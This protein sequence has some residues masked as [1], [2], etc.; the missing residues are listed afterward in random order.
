M[1]RSSARVVRLAAAILAMFVLIE[2]TALAQY[3]VTYLDANQAGKAIQPPDPNLVNAW[4]IARAPNSPYWVSDNGTGK[5]TL[6]TADGTPQGLVVE[7]PAAS[8]QGPGTPSGIVFNGNNV[9]NVSK[10]GMSGPA[11]FIF[12]TQDG[13]ISGWN[14]GVDL[15]HAVIAVDKSASGTVYTGLAIA[16]DINW[17]YAA[18]NSATG[19]KNAVNVYDANF[20]HIDT[21]NDPAIPDGFAAYGV[22]VIGH[23]VFVTYA[24][25]SNAPGGFID[26]FG[27][28]GGTP[29]RFASNGTLNQPWGLALAPGNFGPL[30]HAILVGNN[31]PD[32]IISAFSRSGKFLGL[33]KSP[34]GSVLHIDQL[35]GL[36]FGSGNAPA[37]ARNELFFTAG[38]QNYANGRFGVIHFK[39]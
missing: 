17:L 4:G 26:T 13:T 15:T 10:N 27:E 22:Q 30:S 31:T 38:P 14:P 1:Q 24:S 39:P 7:I 20:N 29:V 16:S 32:G 2:G 5:S 37:G 11:I 21:F 36:E 9:F 35:W 33:L 19:P 34:A 8:G 23:E 18:D 6:Y 25:T 28:F 3:T 12:D